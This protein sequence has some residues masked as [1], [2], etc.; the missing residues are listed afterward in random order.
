MIADSYEWMQ[1]GRDEVRLVAGDSDCGPVVEKLQGRLASPNARPAHGAVASE[2]RLTFL[3]RLELRD[4]DQVQTWNSLRLFA[5]RRARRVEE[6][7]PGPPH[8]CSR[9]S[10]GSGLRRYHAG[11]GEQKEVEMTT[12]SELK[13]KRVSRLWRIR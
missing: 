8:G 12:R 11:F 1:Q 3:A 5:P 9:R 10:C 7:R 13:V 6:D 4:E 2:N